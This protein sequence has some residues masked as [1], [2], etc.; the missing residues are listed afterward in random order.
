MLKT[1]YSWRKALGGIYTFGN[2]GQILFIQLDADE[3]RD[4]T[5]LRGNCR[6]ADTEEWTE[7]GQLRAATAQLDAALHELNWERRRMRP[8]TRPALDRLVRNEPG[9]AAATAVTAIR[10]AQCAMLLLSA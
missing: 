4:I 6:V 2:H 1:P 8:L 10:V 5:I 9:I 3:F 7:H